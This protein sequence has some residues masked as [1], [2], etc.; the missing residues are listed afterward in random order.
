MIRVS[1]PARAY[2][3]GSS[4]LLRAFALSDRRSRMHPDAR[5][6][7]RNDASPARRAGGDG[8]DGD[9]EDGQKDGAKAVF[10][11]APPCPAVI[12]AA[13]RSRRRRRFDLEAIAR[14]ELDVDLRPSVFARPAEMSVFFPWPGPAALD[15]IRGKRRLSD[16]MVRAA[17]TRNSYSR[18]IPSPPRQRP[19]PPEPFR[20]PYR[21][22]SAADNSRAPPRAY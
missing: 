11:W 2:S 5:T 7:M 14:T 16:M 8:Q 21:R 1:T 20:R 3:Q 4:H 6:G 12:G 18:T 15:A 19:R 9:R 22:I 17:G 13:G 10:S